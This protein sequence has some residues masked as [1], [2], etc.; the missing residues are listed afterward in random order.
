MKIKFGAIVV[1]GRNKIG[2]HVMSKNR[3]GAYMR[4]KVTPVNPRSI[5]Q[6]NT[7]NRLS[8]IST[9]WDGLS[10]SQISA[11]NSAVSQWSHTDIF[12]DIKHPSGFNLFQ[13]LNNNILRVG[14]T[15]LTTP[16]VKVELSFLGKLTCG[17]VAASALPLTFD[18]QSLGSNEKLEISATPVVSVGK[19]FVKSEYRIIGHSLTLTAGA[20]DCGSLWISKFGS[21]LD[22]AGKIF[23]SA[24]IVNSVSG[25]AGVPVS[26]FSIS[27]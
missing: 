16:P 21:Y 8:S 4:T 1:D 6:E 26:A 2:G 20:T 18:L 7:R 5:D 3:A 11:W 9:S 27:D 22:A 14:G 19:S 17:T 13:K 25:Q 10:S 23:I 24:R 12:G 15:A